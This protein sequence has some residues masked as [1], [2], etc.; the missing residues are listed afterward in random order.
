MLKIFVIVFV[1]L[2]LFAAQNT[3]NIIPIADEANAL[4]QSVQN[5]VERA[6]DL[7]DNHLAKL[8]VYD[9]FK[10]NGLNRTECAKRIISL[11]RVKDG[12]GF[13]LSPTNGVSDLEATII[14]R[15]ILEG[16]LQ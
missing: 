8:V 2:G 7:S 10:T 5:E 6:L 11:Q 12:K 16:V 13:W 4:E 3:I 9:I 15:R 14:A 1:T